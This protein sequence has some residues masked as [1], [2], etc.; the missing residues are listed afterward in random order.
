MFAPLFAGQTGRSV[1]LPAG[2]W[3]DFFTGK[4]FEGG[5]RFDIDCALD[6]ML[7]F[8][9]SG[10]ILPVAEPTEYISKDAPLQIKFVKYGCG[11][12]ETVL[13]DDDGESYD[14][15]RGRINIITV[16]SDNDGNTTV[17]NDSDYRGDRYVFKAVL[18]KAY[19]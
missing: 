19:N 5:K 13:V 4:I 8:V 14:Y 16:R 6:K 1:Y 17:C 15:R 9:R 18:D 11:T 3:Y 7:L 12:A 10:T 2:C